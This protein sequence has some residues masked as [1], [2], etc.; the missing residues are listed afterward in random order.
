[1]TDV[2]IAEWTPRSGRK[3]RVVFLNDDFWG[4]VD[5]PDVST[6]QKHFEDA[7]RKSSGGKVSLYKPGSPYR[8]EVT[9][10][11]DQANLHIFEDAAT[12]AAPVRTLTTQIATASRPKPSTAV[13]APIRRRKA[14]ASGYT[15][16]WAAL[17]AVPSS[18]TEIDW[19]ASPD[20]R[21]SR[22]ERLR[23][24]WF[25]TTRNFWFYKP[26]QE[27]HLTATLWENFSLFH[28][29][30]F[31][32]EL[33][34]TAGLEP[35]VNVT[36]ACWSYEFE[37]RVDGHLKQTDVTLHYHDGHGDALLVVE[38]KRPRGPLKPS[39]Q[40]A[41]YYLDLP[42]FQFTSRKHVIYL[43]DHADLPGVRS[44][45]TSASASAPGFLS[46]QQF[47]ALQARLTGSLPV[48]E[49]LQ[50]LLAALIQWQFERHGFTLPGSRAEYPSKDASLAELL[51]AN[52]L[53]LTSTANAAREGSLAE[54]A[55][56]QLC[57]AL[58]L[59]I[60]LHI[61]GFLV[62]AIQHQC[63]SCGVIPSRLTCEYL[64]EEPSQAEIVPGM[65]GRQRTAE[66]RKTLWK[67]PSE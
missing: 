48:S 24:V 37:E 67:I 62:G 41:A 4:Y 55:A 22:Y 16:W 11:L 56:E 10:A 65:E 2:K 50:R 31:L 14:Q 34:Q 15:H 44:A 45:V 33:F 53:L 6:S 8:D 7:L 17:P 9:P 58:S 52:G 12:T 40:N 46:W 21:A 27:D 30:I 25:D 49:H 43:V 66:R 5:L 39:D 23:R 47:G 13:N 42:S 32:P 59:D 1:M 60:P 19:W 38:A 64:Q 35:P 36:D 26:D 3:L 51:R 28:P 54:I 18:R 57:L 20:G 61:K 63:C 29:S